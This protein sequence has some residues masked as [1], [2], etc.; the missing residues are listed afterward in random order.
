MNGLFF[1]LN[2]I[3][4]FRFTYRTM[5]LKTLRAVFLYKD[6]FIFLCEDTFIFQYLPV[7]VSIHDVNVCIHNFLVRFCLR[8]LKI[9]FDLRLCVL[10][11]PCCD[12]QT[13]VRRFGYLNTILLLLVETDIIFS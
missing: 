1:L 11:L 2:L 8:T 7:N 5:R 13:L 3:R 6:T 9:S 4:L 10:D 12:F